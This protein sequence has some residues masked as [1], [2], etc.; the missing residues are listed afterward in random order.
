MGGEEICSRTL[1]GDV[2]FEKAEL[3]KR[4]ETHVRSS[5]CAD[6]NRGNSNGRNGVVGR[7]RG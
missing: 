6:Q 5:A 7:G 3:G 1:L 4:F 2:E